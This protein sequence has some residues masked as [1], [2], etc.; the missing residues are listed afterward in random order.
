MQIIKKKMN[1]S[2]LR[3]WGAGGQQIENEKKD[4]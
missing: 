3:F 4:G 1:L 2:F